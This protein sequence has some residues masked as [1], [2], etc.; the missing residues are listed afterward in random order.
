MKFKILSNV[1]LYHFDLQY[2][3][4]YSKKVSAYVRRFDIVVIDGRDRINCANTAT[5]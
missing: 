5:N 2:G 3:G 1:E 4:E